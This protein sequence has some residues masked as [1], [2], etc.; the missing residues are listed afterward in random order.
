MAAIKTKHVHLHWV[1]VHTVPLRRVPIKS[2]GHQFI[3]HTPW[4]IKNVPLLFFEQL[5]AALA[6][7]N[8][9]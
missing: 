1:T 8:N 9:F 4:S 6:D 3:P 7:F 2:H 5:Q